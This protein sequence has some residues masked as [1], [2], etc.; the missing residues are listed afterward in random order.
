M[1]NKN[2]TSID[3]L[4]NSDNKGLNYL[5]AKVQ[6]HQRLQAALD[7]SIPAPLT[8]HCKV[9]NLRNGCLVIQTDSPAWLTKLRYSSPDIL[10]A[11]RRI[12]GLQGLRRLE[13]YI[14]PPQ[15]VKAPIKIQRK[16]LSHNNA[17]LLNS[18]ANG[19]KDEALKATLKRLTNHT[20]SEQ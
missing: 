9:A 16:L 18:I 5:V 19:I 7:A 13:F 2:H 4:L 12:D 14:E 17:N 10:Q 20:K 15:Q 11:L 3:D 6:Q 1:K 8:E